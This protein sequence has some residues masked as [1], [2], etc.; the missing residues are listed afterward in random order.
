M[1]DGR[2]AVE[3][4]LA[5]ACYPSSRLLEESQALARELADKAPISI[6]MAKRHLQSATDIDFVTALEHEAES[7]LTCMSTED[8]REGLRAFGEKRK[9]RF[10]G[11]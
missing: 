9:P 8:W 6:T 4:G 10:M 11:K 1:L 7:I 5:L 2:A 3:I